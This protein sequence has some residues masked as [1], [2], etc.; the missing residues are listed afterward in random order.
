MTCE[1]VCAS[2]SS[3]CSFC[4]VFYSDSENGLKLTNLTQSKLNNMYLHCWQLLAK[5][6]TLYNHSCLR[7]QHSLLKVPAHKYQ[8]I[9][10]VSI[11]SWPCSYALIVTCSLIT[12]I[13]VNSHGRGFSS[14]HRKTCNQ[15][16]MDLSIRPNIYLSTN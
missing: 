4:F 3:Y 6:F 2:R 5:L 10:F 9:L 7:E 16:Q 12:N 15:V 14:E 1:N 8:F 13:T 11:R